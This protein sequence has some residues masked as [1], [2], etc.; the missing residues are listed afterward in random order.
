MCF[1]NSF[2]YNKGEK[3]YYVL[4]KFREVFNKINVNVDTILK[5]LEDKCTL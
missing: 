3:I 1:N 4:K 2:G 5:K